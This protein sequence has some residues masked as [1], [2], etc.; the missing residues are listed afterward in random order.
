MES[1]HMKSKVNVKAILTRGLKEK[2]QQE[3]KDL[4][5]EI[6]MELEQIDFKSKRLMENI[7]KTNPQQRLELKQEMDQKKGAAYSKRERIENRLKK[8]EKLEYGDE[9]HQKT[10]N[11]LATISVGDDLEEKMI[12]EIV[13]KDG[14]VVEIR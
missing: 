3:L 4:L 11:G 13:V 12:R 8:L 9:V 2:M 6:D 5:K 14:K 10:L 1:I 7:D